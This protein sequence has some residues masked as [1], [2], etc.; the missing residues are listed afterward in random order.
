MQIDMNALARAG[1]HTRLAELSAE[2][3]AI[4]AAFPDLGGAPAKKRGRPARRAVSKPAPPKSTPKAKGM[5]AAAR[6]AVGE[7]MTAYW[8]KR[9]VSAPATE[10]ATASAP[11]ATT[12]KPAVKAKRT[13]S[14]EARARISAAVKKRWK[15]HR[16]GKKAA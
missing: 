11:E 15:A 8:A 10:P 5:S 12:E 2:V 9:R 4:H 6:K 14:P 3:D 7:R 13:M 1:A 16:K